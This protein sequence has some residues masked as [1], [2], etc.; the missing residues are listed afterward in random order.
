MSYLDSKYISHWK[1]APAKSKAVKKDK[2]EY[3]ED[4]LQMAIVAYLR[5]L[6]PEVKLSTSLLQGTVKSAI[7]GAKANRMGYTKGMPDLFIAEPMKGYH[8]IFLELKNGK[9]GVI[10]KEQQA[11]LEYLQGKGYY[12]AVVRDF[13][14]GKAIIDSYFTE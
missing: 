1:P 14:S 3:S 2:K 4:D 7:L 11:A 9:K 12:V 6:I 10:T 13:Q 5:K 8:G